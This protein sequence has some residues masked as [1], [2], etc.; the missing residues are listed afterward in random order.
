MVVGDGVMRVGV[1]S[2]DAMGVPVKVASGCVGVSDEMI[3]V[4]GSVAVMGG[5][6]ITGVGE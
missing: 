4:A 1:I 5:A 6:R 3:G 2:V